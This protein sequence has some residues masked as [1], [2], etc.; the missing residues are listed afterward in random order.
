MTNGTQWSSWLMNDRWFT[1]LPASLQDSLLSGMQQRRF[2]S[3][4]TVFERGQPVTGLYALLDGSIRFGDP[5]QQCHDLPRPVGKRPY[6]F[7]E[8]ALFDDQ[9][10]A[11]DGFAEGSI[12]LLHMPHAPIRQLLQERPALWRHFC[13]L[14]SQKLGLLVPL[15]E[16]MTLLPTVERVAFRLLML[17]EGYGELDRSVRVVALSNMASPRCLGLIGEVVERVLGELAE[18]NI[19]RREGDLIHVLD[20]GRL[21]RAALHRLTE[22]KN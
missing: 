21:R 16:Q 2:T 19:V 18:R 8:R 20:T 9:P 3:G 6:W 17:T 13:A 14:L 7:G 1:E 5:A 12:I 11:L 22:E 10:S 4:R 15:P